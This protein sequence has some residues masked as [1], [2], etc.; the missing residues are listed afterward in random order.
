MTYCIFVQSLNGRKP[1]EVEKKLVIQARSRVQI[2]IPTVSSKP[3]FCQFHPVLFVAR[4]RKALSPAEFYVISGLR[5]A[6]TRFS[7]FESQSSFCSNATRADFTWMMGGYY[8]SLQPNMYFKR[9]V[10]GHSLLFALSLGC[11]FALLLASSVQKLA[12]LSNPFLSAS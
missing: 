11:E 6:C 3:A 9:E 10:R 5:S 1:F 2:L 8:F 7:I 4:Y 12:F